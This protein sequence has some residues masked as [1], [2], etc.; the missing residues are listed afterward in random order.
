MI[1]YSWNITSV[2]VMTYRGYDNIV[3]KVYYEFKGEYLEHNH[4]IRGVCIL[5]LNSLDTV[6]PISFE[7]L[8]QE[9]VINWLKNSLPVGKERGY[10]VECANVIT[11]MVYPL[12]VNKIIEE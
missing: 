2:D 10:M 8:N 11:E 3:R 4:T 7:N 1:T 5:K 9:I 6:D 12:Y